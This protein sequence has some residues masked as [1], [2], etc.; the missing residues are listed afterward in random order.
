ME[1]YSID[2]NMLDN[3][4]GDTVCVI[5]TMDDYD[6]A[7][8]NLKMHFRIK[9]GAILVLEE[10]YSAFDTADYKLK[11]IEGDTITETKFSATSEWATRHIKQNLNRHLDVFDK[12]EWFIGDTDLF[13]DQYNDIIALLCVAEQNAPQT[14]TYTKGE[15]DND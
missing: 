10:E 3:E 4:V 15:N 9:D 1:F 6:W 14:K 13:I 7:T 5:L 12:A 8:Y 11:R 2:K